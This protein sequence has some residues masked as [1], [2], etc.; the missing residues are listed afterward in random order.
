MA[1]H[2][3]AASDNGVDTSKILVIVDFIEEIS[4]KQLLVQCVTCKSNITLLLS[5]QE[6][7]QTLHLAF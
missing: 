4:K 5:L 3:T 1:L 2:T 6:E 7:K